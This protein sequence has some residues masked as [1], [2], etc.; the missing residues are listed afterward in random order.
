MKL[1][2]NADGVAASGSTTRMTFGHYVPLKVTAV[3]LSSFSAHR[4]FATLRM[5]CEENDAKFST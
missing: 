2:P 1:Y 3:R 4:F 5:T